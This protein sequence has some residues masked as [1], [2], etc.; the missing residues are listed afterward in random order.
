MVRSGG[1]VRLSRIEALR[2]NTRGC[3]S[4]PSLMTT[5]GP[6][7]EVQVSRSLSNSQK[8]RQ[9]PDLGRRR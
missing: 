7:M 3:E 5:R 9:S 8:Q 1:P 6:N 4:G 2:S